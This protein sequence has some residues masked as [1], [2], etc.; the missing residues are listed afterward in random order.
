MEIAFD[1]LPGKVFK[2][3]VRSIGFGVAIDTAALG[4]LPTIDNNRQW[5][6]DAQRFPVLVDV[7]DLGSSNLSGIRVGSQASVMVYTGGS[8]I[9]NSIAWIYVRTAS[10]LSYAY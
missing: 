2:G 9:L 1:A 4:A 3:R 7:D 6:R 5:L 8:W 10:I